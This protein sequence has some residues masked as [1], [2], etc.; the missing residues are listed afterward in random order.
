MLTKILAGSNE[1]QRKFL[2]IFLFTKEVSLCHYKHIHF[3][4]L[5][6]QRR[7]F[8]QLSTNRAELPPLYCKLLM[9]GELKQFM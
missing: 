1:V 8:A 5:I 3:T 6:T 9:R 7:W 4:N 2:C